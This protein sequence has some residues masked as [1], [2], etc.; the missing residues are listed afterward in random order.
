MVGEY[1]S[2]KVLPV[3]LKAAEDTD[4]GVRES[5]VFGMM[6]LGD[7]GG[8]PAV[9]RALNDESPSVRRAAAYCVV[10]VA[11]GEPWLLEELLPLLADPDESVREAAV[12]SLDAVDPD[13]R[14]REDIPPK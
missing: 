14:D 6:S 10:A 13:W 4:D 3:L 11:R 5:A 9:R 12:S 2:K 1:G 7:P 8:A